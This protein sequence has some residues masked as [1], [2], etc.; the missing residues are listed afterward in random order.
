M[1]IVSC[2]VTL[3]F[4]SVRAQSA[5]AADRPPSALLQLGEAAMAPFDRIEQLLLRR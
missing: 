3:P 1:A 5:P 4:P 2:I